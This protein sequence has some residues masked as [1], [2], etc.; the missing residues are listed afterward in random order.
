M[1]AAEANFCV[2]L[3]AC[4][5]PTSGRSFV[6]RND[7]VDRLNDYKCGL[8]FWLCLKAPEIKSII[9]VENSMYPLD[10]LREI[11]DRENVHGRAIEF[12]STEPIELPAGVTYG[13]GELAM[14]DSVIER[15]RL[16]QA[17][18]YML[19]ATGRLRFPGV[20]KLI[21][22]VSYPF[23]FVA[24]ARDDGFLRTQRRQFIPTQLILF[25]SRFYRETLLNCKERMPTKWVWIENMLYDLLIS[26]RKTEGAYF[27]FPISV[28][29]VG[30]AGHS[31][32]SY[33]SY[34]RRTANL[35]RRLGRTLYPWW[36]M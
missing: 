7:P 27:R 17:S 36:W 21:S 1:N 18:E 26:Y 4:I 15:S 25:N 16:F 29:P 19:K 8:R 14:I 23:K 13:Y 32:R 20:E 12:L 24:D 30:F 22:S 28:D 6:I 35:I 11:A 2:I 33:S 10:E 3:T 31:G 34:S 9:F 5:A